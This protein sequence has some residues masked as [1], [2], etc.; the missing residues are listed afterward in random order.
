MKSSQAMDTQ[1]DEQA[2]MKLTPQRLKAF[3]TACYRL[4]SVFY[5]ERC[6][7]F[8][9]DMMDSEEKQR[10]DQLHN[11]LDLIS[12]VQSNKGS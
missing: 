3:K 7:E 8:H 12:K 5:C 9:T 11:N 10:Y 1:F 2:L 6:R 4:K